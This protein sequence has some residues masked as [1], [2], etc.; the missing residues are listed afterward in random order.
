MAWQMAIAPF[1]FGLV[2]LSSRSICYFAFCHPKSRWRLPH[3]CNCTRD[4]T[5]I[6]PNS[7]VTSNKKAHKKNTIS[8]SFSHPFTWCVPFYSE[9]YLQKPLYRS[10]W[11]AVKEFQPVR[12]WFFEQ[13]NTPCERVRKI[14]PENGIFSCVLFCSG[15]LRVLKDMCENFEAMKIHE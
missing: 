14:V 1:T 4:R 15:H 2:L 11:L 13:R 8:G 5:H 12:R 3:L 9:C 6:F 7:R 10:F